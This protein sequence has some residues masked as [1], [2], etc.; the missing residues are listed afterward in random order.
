ML[1]RK[2]ERKNR[3]EKKDYKSYH[4]VDG[5]KRI[6]HLDVGKI[7]TCFEVAGEYQIKRK[8][9]LSC[10]KLFFSVQCL[11]RQLIKQRKQNS[12]YD[13]EKS[14]IAAFKVFIFE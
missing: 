12:F 8:K 7:S 2:H 9:S 6:S 3:S 1:E 4:K 13:I 10:H 5:C 11:P 14:F